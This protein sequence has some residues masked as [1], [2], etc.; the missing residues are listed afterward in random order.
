[1]EI[2]E[3]DL[4]KDGRQI[5]QAL[6]DLTGQYTFPNFFKNGKSLG[7]FDRLSE[8]DRQGQLAGLCS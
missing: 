8:L 5:Q 7:G 3:V 1:M 2:I 4:R 6:Y